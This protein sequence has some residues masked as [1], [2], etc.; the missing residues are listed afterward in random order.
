MPTLLLTIAPEQISPEILTA[1]HQALSSHLALLH[2][3]DEAIIR[4]HAA[5][6]E[7]VAGWFKQDWLL[8]LPNLRWL[9]QWGAGANWILE[10]E[11]LRQRPFTLTNVSGVHAIPISEHIFAMLLALGRNLRHAHEALAMMKL[12]GWASTW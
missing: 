11:E 9:Q 6:I 7:I 3:Q 2:T 4:Q 10:S 5:D 8:E 1:V 12:S